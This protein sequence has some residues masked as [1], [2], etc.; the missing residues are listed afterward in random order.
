MLELKLAIEAMHKRLVVQEGK[1]VVQV[2]TLEEQKAMNFNTTKDAAKF[3][4]DCK[5]LQG[6]PEAD[7]QHLREHVDAISNGLKPLIIGA[8]M[9]SIES[10]VE[11]ITRDL[12]KVMQLVH[13]HEQRELEMAA[14]LENVVAPAV[15]ER[16]AE[17]QYVLSA[18][19]RDPSRSSRRYA[20]TS[21]R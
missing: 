8:T 10:R 1:L 16:P 18:P 15:G 6:I 13:G 4:G 17:G 19:S 7:R 5:A 20:R 21:A 11:L 12:G 2:K 9:E 3:K 14:Y